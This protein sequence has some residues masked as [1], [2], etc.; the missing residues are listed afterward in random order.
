MTLPETLRRWLAAHP[1]VAVWDEA[2]GTLLDLSSGKTLAFDPRTITRFEEKE[3]R[4]TGGTYLVL[5]RED[6]RQLVLAD[7][8][9][10]W[11]PG[12]E[13]TGPL[14]FLPPVVCW[15]DYRRLVDEV[16]HRVRAHPEVPPDRGV[17][18]LILVSIALLEGAR[19]LGFEVG[20]EEGEVESLLTELERRKRG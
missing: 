20:R 18:D 14:D 8:G 1:Q 7:A 12:T 3:N 19:S 13:S 6:G 17:L 5:L 2:A 10:A 16:A 4:E 11:E 15:R 9:I